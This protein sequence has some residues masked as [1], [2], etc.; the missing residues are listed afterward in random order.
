MWMLDG[1]VLFCER[2][3]IS[4]TTK[5]SKCKEELIVLTDVDKA[6]KEK[7]IGFSLS[8]LPQQHSRTILICYGPLLNPPRHQRDDAPLLLHCRQLE[9][10]VQ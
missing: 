6:E 10:R 3:A 4:H 1:A 8:A 7:Q 5:P 2:K 9:P